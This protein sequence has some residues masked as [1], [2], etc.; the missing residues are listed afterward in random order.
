M[1]AIT[2]KQKEIG[3]DNLVQG[4]YSEH[5]IILQ[6]DLTKRNKDKRKLKK[7]KKE[8]KHTTELPKKKKKLKKMYFNTSLTTSP[9]LSL[10]YGLKGT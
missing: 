9:L 3:W 1:L 8:C 6:Y 7:I 10:N 4:K 2:K 5:W